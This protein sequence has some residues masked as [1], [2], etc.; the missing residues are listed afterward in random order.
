VS[1]FFRLYA[2]I[3]TEHMSVQEC[4]VLAGRSTKPAAQTTDQSSPNQRPEQQ[5]R[6]LLGALDF[7]GGLLGPQLPKDD[8]FTLDHSLVEEY[9]HKQAPFGFNGL[10]EVVYLRTYARDRSDGRSEVWIDTVERVVNGVFEILQHHA[11]NRLHGTWDPEKARE[12][13]KD[14]FHRIFDMKFLPPGRGLWA[15]GA[16]VVTKKGLAAAL[17]NCAFVSTASLSSDRLRPFLFLMDASMLGVGVGFDTAGAGSFVIV[18]P[19]LTQPPSTL[20]IPDDREGWVESL[21]RLLQSYF[22]G[23]PSVDFDYSHI[24][25]IG[26]KLQ[27]FG[28]TSSGPGPLKN[29]H[30]Q[31]HNLLDDERGKPISVTT[32]TD[33]MNLIGVCVVAGNIRRSA[34]IA[35]GQPDCEEFLDL[36]NYTINPQRQAYGWA[37]NNSIFANIGMDYSDV[38]TRISTNGEPGFAWLSNMQA[39]SRMDGKADNRDTRVLG[40]DPCLESSFESMELCSLV[41]TFPDKHDTFEDFKRTLSSALLFAKTVTLL[42]LHWR[43]SNEIWMRNRRLGCSVSGIAQ[44]IAHRGLDE[45][46]D[47]LEHGY[48]ALRDCDRQI[49]EWLCVRESIK[50]TSV[51]PSGTIS[52]LAGATPGIHYPESRYYIRRLRIARDSPLLDRIVRAGYHVEP[53]AVSPNLTAIVEFPVAAGEDLRTTRDMTM[54]EQLSLAAFMQRYWADNQVSATVTFDPATEGPHLAHALE[55]FQFQLKGISFLPRFSDGTTAYKQMPYEGITEDQ[56]LEALRKL[57]PN[58]SLS[59][60]PKA[61]ILEETPHIG[62]TNDP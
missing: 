58:V 25:E 43:E 21:K 8:R 60:T 12:R 30:S 22:F 53:C 34:E 41:E 26:A 6:S 55:Y 20:I 37:S 11:V 62:C 46:K 31:I 35:L 27:T 44:F 17:C 32:I 56:Y 47:W 33:I 3:A 50:L 10:G 29:L 9:R 7:Y 1:I 15:M 5:T 42:P 51:K 59:P 52:L 2:M 36:K 48:E 19:D 61:V 14:M 54:W 28:G 45:L 38:C 24:R 23:T 40:G 39:F 18:G 49:S 4:S 57:H 13:A 16:P